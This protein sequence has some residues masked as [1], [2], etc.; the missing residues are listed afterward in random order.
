MVQLSIVDVKVI[1]GV[2]PHNSKYQ[3]IVENE[4]VQ[5]GGTDRFNRQ[6]NQHQ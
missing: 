4:I 1:V 2:Q 5:V 6:Y 3:P